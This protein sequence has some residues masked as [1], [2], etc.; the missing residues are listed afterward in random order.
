MLPLKPS[1]H[2]T[3]RYCMAL[4]TTLLSIVRSA[5]PYLILETAYLNTPSTLYPL[6]THQAKRSRKDD[7]FPDRCVSCH[8]DEEVVTGVPVADPLAVPVTI[9][10]DGVE[11]VLVVL[12]FVMVDVD[13]VV[14]GT[15][16][17]T[18]LLPLFT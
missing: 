1:S 10:E 16:W 18:V 12:I 11:T 3:G 15:I 14:M 7:V 6:Y 2:T 17:F 9:V 4:L 8:C 5:I 13:E